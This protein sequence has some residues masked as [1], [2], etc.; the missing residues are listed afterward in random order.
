MSIFFFFLMIRRPP[1]STLFPY[2]T[3]FRSPHLRN[4]PWRRAV[5]A[6]DV[7]EP[8]RAQPHARVQDHP[9]SHDR[10]AVTHHVGHDLYVV[11]QLHAV[12]QDHT[13]GNPHVAAEAYVPAEH[14]VRSDRNGLLPND[15]PFDHRRAMR[16]RLPSRLRVEHGD[17]RE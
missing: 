12:S 14:R 7:A 8:I 1:R 11:P 15:A 3:L 2:T 4:L 6:R 9:A 16:A 13:R 10:A 17:D 5:L